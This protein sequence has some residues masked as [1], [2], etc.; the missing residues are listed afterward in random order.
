S[1]R[2]LLSLSS[3]IFGRPPSSLRRRS[4][5]RNTSCLRPAGSRS[6]TSF[7]A[8]CRSRDSGWRGSPS[9]TLVALACAFSLLTSASASEKK[10]TEED[11]I[12]LLRGLMSEY[13]TVKSYL[14][15]SK[16]PLPFDSTGTWDK[17]KWEEMGREL[18]PA[19][20]V[21]D[22]VQVTR[23]SIEGDKILLEI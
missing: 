20:R 13:A 16:K 4:C 6:G 11:R 14:P 22:L 17:Q 12:E 2:E 18:G 9:S 3:F 19:A 15:R 21:G 7:H 5:S 8:S 23:I 1:L 10:L